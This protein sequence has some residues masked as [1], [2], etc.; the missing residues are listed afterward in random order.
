M[1]SGTK[2]EMSSHS[3][4]EA[5][6][7]SRGEKATAIRID[8][9]RNTMKGYNSRD[10]QVRQLASSY[11]LANWKEVSNFGKSIY[12]NEDDIVS[13]LGSWK[14]GDEIHTDFVPFPLGNRQRLKCT[15]RYLMLCLNATT[16]ITFGNK[17]S[18]VSLHPS[19][20]KSLA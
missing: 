15:S 14:A 5:S 1:E 11:R 19:P 18:N 3:I 17:L 12:D 10:V 2:G 8:F 13:F 7:N 6:P 16:N 4:L 20:P 9:Q